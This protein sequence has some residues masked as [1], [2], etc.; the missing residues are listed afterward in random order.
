[1]DDGRALA[2]GRE[3]LLA[4]ALELFLE[5]GYD[6]VSMQQ[7]AD[8]AAMTKGAPYHHFASKE[9][10]F[11]QALGRHFDLIHAGL[12]AELREVGGLRETMTASLAYLIAHCDAGMVRLVDDLRRLVGA[13][14]M[15]EY[16]ASLDRLRECNLHLFRRAAAEGAAL[17]CTP[18]QAAEF[19]LAVEIGEL[20]LLELGGGRCAAPETILPRAGW[21]ADAVL[22]GLLAGEAGSVRNAPVAATGGAESGGERC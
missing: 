3:R 10:L 20:T 15:V 17:T 19:F 13:E 22:H 4:S 18:E 5:A 11:G 21:V 8:A 1:M 14:R 9:D 2:G 6:G 16:G 7:I 12:E